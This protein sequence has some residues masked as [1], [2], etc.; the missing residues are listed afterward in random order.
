[1]P[2]F[3]SSYFYVFLFC[4]KSKGLNMGICIFINRFVEK[5]TKLKIEKMEVKKKR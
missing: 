3:N 5:K 1:M 2:I 4:E